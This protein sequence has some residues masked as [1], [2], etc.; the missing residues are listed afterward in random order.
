MLFP[1]RKKTVFH[2]TAFFVL[3]FMLFAI[4]PATCTFAEEESSLPLVGTKV[5]F[6]RFEQ[7]GNQSNGP[8]DLKWLVLDCDEEAGT[9]LLITAKGIAHIK[10][11]ET[12]LNENRTRVYWKHS[13]LRAWLNGDFYTNAFTDEEKA[14]IESTAVSGVGNAYGGVQP[15]PATRDNIYILSMDEYKQYF[16][17]E[18]D[19]VC[20]ATIAA[21]KDGAHVSGTDRICWWWLRDPGEPGDYAMHTS[22]DG[23][24]HVYGN[25]IDCNGGTVRPVMRVRWE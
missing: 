12:P 10:Y 17:Q 21:C 13:S 22:Y 6:G 16:E 1:F 23:S 20:P 19:G 9:V 11:N 3:L 15:G 14:Q 8:E 7:D 5:N 25:R 24:V 18:E 2:I 4:F